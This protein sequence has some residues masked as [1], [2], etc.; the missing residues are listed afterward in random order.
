MKRSFNICRDFCRPALNRGIVYALLILSADTNLA[1]SPSTTS[2]T[3]Q[4]ALKGADG[5]PLPDGKP[6]FTFKFYDVLTG[7]TAL[8]TSNVPNVP[9]TGGIA[10]T[11][12][13]VDPATFNGQ[14][15]YLGAAIN[16][17]QELLPRMLITAVPYALNARAVGDLDSL[18]VV[19]NIEI[20]NAAGA[21]HRALVFNGPNG[22]EGYDGTYQDILFRFNSAG[23]SIVRAFRGSSFDTYLEFLVSNSE[24]PTVTRRLL[25]TPGGI[26]VNGT[27][28]TKLLQITGGADLAEPF[29]VTPD[30]SGVAIVPGMVTVIDREHDGKLAPCS[31]AYDTA[32]AVVISGANGLSPGLV[33][34]AEGQPFA[35]GERPLAL[36]GRVWCWVDASIKNGGGPVRRGD[37]LTTSSTYGH[38]MKVTEEAKAPGTV[39]GKAM[40]E[41]PEGKGLVL[42]LVNLQ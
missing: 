19:G 9:V 42:V 30:A 23:S 18:R 37:R 38:A 16:G 29:D 3:F 21:T 1:Q 11:A 31:R 34:K 15:R 24:G 28:K 7:G 5:R 14:T 6:N 2:I 4:G 40:T 27:T 22:P 35:D 13:P 25:I 33:M 26:E 41:L 39:I 20:G 32:V 36:S 8:A 17:G 12:V 10:S